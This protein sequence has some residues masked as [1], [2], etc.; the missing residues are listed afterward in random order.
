MQSSIIFPL[1]VS[2]ALFFTVYFFTIKQPNDS[3]SFLYSKQNCIDNT[4]VAL[5]GVDVVEYFSLPENSPAVYGST[6]Y[7][8]RY[9]GF[10]FLFSSEANMQLFESNSSKYTPRW[11]G[12]CSYGIAREDW[13]KN[14]LGPPT[15]T[16]IWE[17]INGSLHFFR[18]VDVRSLFD[19]H[20][21]DDIQFGNE[22]W[23][24]WFGDYD[25]PYNTKC[26]MINGTEVTL[27]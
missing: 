7:T 13:S 10:Q 27:R 4:L 22:R 25:S 2:S 3:S 15:D 20:H 11:G 14:L 21:Q 17:I 23:E 16:D 24:N 1:F 18:D 8:V 5:D 19:Q 12:F 26:F 9:K 6:K